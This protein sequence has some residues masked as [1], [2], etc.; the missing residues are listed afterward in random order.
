MNENHHVGIT[1][2]EPRWY[3]GAVKKIA[4]L[5]RDGRE[6][7]WRTAVNDVGEGR[8]PRNTK[9]LPAAHVSIDP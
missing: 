2:E 9:Y 5:I 1:R 7:R 4:W 8:V 3:R 6:G